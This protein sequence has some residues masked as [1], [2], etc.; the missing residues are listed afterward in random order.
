MSPVNPVIEADGDD[1][2]HFDY[3]I[4]KRNVSW[5]GQCYETFISP[6]LA[7]GPYLRDRHPNLRR[8]LAINTNIVLL[9]SHRFKYI[10]LFFI[11]NICFIS[12]FSS[13]NLLRFK[14]NCRIKLNTI[15]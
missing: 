10:V 4:L 13:V 8:P 11:Y 5:S 14:L 6:S 9:S 2:L 15:F 12:Y 3:I 1:T 7:A